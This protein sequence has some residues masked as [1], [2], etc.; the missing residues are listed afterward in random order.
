MTTLLETI[1]SRDEVQQTVALYAFMGGIYGANANKMLEVGLEALVEV[2]NE[3]MAD[4]KGKQRS[5]DEIAREIFSYM[6]L[7][8]VMLQNHLGNAEEAVF[9]EKYKELFEDAR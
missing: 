8:V 5:D 6:G 3:T 2:I 7:L 1:R 4:N 9:V